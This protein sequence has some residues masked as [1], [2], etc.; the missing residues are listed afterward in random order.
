ML[1]LLLYEA[2]EILY[3]TG[4]LLGNGLYG[5]YALIYGVEPDPENPEDMDRLQQLEQR[6]QELEARLSNEKQNQNNKQDEPTTET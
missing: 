1:G 2:F 6:I 4:K 3:Y 5:I